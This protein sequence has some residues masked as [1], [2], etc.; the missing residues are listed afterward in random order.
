[1]ASIGFS[2]IGCPATLN[3]VFKRTGTPEILAN[4]LSN[5]CINGSDSE[6]TD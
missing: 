2:T 1:M 5:R 6:V 3:D 4:L